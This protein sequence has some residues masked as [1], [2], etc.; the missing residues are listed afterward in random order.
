MYIGQSVVYIQGEHETLYNG[1]NNHP[2]IITQVWSP[3]C[4]N[5]KVFFDCG[6]VEDRTSVC[7][8]DQ[9]QKGGAYFEYNNYNLDNKIKSIVLEMI[10][11]IKQAMAEEVCKGI[12][13][14]KRLE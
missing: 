6:P 1:H 4:V 14:S 3:T 10:P 12:E 9:I 5:L 11:A 2:A 8:L 13:L 7:T